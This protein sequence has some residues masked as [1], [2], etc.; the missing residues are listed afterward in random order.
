[1]KT[2]SI[3]RQAE[4]AVVQELIFQGYKILER[5][6]RTRWCEV[7][8][9]GKKDKIIYF[10]EVKYRTAQSQGSGFDYIGPNKQSQL[11][12][13]AQLWVANNNWQ[14]DCRILA[15]EVSGSGHQYISLV[16]ID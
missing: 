14:G 16:E 10:V 6:W 3:G 7:D 12:F 8:I 9:V 2:T 4:N 13:A 11:T 5:N 1:M 15:A